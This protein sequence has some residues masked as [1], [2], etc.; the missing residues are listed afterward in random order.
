MA[1]RH[2]KRKAFW[3]A[4]ARGWKRLRQAGLTRPEG[5][6]FGMT[7]LGGGASRGWRRFVPQGKRGAHLRIQRQ[8]N[9]RSLT[10][11]PQLLRAGFGMTGR[12]GT[13]LGESPASAGRAHTADF[14]ML[15]CL[16]QPLGRFGMTVLGGGANR[17]WRRFVPQG[18]EER[19]Y[20]TRDNATGGVAHHGGQA[21][22]DSENEQQIP[23]CGRPASHGRK[24]AGSE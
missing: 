23:A 15:G 2:K 18:N 20:K 12:E 11:I 10:A 6:R 21:R 1:D 16:P 14:F 24:A 7:V 17:G 4:G 3:K 9:S 19:T 5:G 8:D 22:N 13:R